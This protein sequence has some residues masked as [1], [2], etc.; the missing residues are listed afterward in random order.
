MDS[1]EEDSEGSGV[2]GFFLGAGFLLFGIGELVRGGDRAVAI[3][4]TV[5]GSVWVAGHA[6]QIFL[7]YEERGESG[8]GEAIGLGGGGKRVMLDSVIMMVRAKIMRLRQTYPAQG[9][10]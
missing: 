10:G 1:G 8:G 6:V 7:F 5:I 4:L 2:L 3:A 9:G